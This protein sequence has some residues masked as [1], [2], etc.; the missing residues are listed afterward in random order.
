MRISKLP[1]AFR[2]YS[3]SDCGW[4]E[5]CR[6]RKWLETE[7]ENKWANVGVN[8]IEIRDPKIEIMFL[9]KWVDCGSRG[10]TV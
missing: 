6:L 10:P 9:L 4:E 5:G 8:L 2:T 3:I 7:G 1:F